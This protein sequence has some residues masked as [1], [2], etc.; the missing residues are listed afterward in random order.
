MGN[1]LTEA[2]RFYGEPL[3]R[4]DAMAK[5]DNVEPI[6]AAHFKM[7]CRIAAD[8]IRHARELQAKA[9]TNMRHWREEVGKLAAAGRAALAQEGGGKP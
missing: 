7:W 1:R 5:S 3:A 4:F 8:E 9:E 6:D 2:D